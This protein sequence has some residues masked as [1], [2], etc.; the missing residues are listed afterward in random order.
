MAAARLLREAHRLEALQLGVAHLVHLVDLV[1]QPLHLYDGMMAKRS[2]KMSTWAASGC[3]RWP[4]ML[5]PAKTAIFLLTKPLHGAVGLPPRVAEVVDLVGELREPGVV[6]QLL[7]AHAAAAR[8]AQL[9][10]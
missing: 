10:L 2:E 8:L 4:A 7:V 5:S 9:H 3:W 1:A 6:A